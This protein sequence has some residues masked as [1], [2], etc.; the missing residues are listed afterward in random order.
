[1]GLTLSKDRLIEAI[2]QKKPLISSEIIAAYYNAL[3]SRI[4]KES[5]E[6]PR[7]KND[8]IFILSRLNE[9]L[10]EW[11]IVTTTINDKDISF[12]VSLKEMLTLVYIALTDKNVFGDNEVDEADRLR[13]LWAS[14]SQIQTKGIDKSFVQKIS[15]KRR[16]DEVIIQAII[17]MSESLNLDVV[18]EGVETKA[19]LEFLENHLCKK[20][21]GYYCSKPILPKELQKL[22]K[23]S[24]G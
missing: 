14:F 4:Q 21:Q 11:D 13:T 12:S 23:K 5:Q 7:L 24:M 9:P 18:A 8:W 2:E 22:F 17:A 15:L 3:A 10:G 20:F 19:Q 6:N 16:S 1:M